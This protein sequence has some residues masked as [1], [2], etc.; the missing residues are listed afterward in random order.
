MKNINLSP[1]D[2]YKIYKISYSVAESRGKKKQNIINEVVIDSLKKLDSYKDCVFKEEVRMNPLWGKYFPVDIAIYRNDVLIEIVLNKAPASNAKQNKV[3]TMNSINSDIDRL[4]NYKNIKITLV[5]F[6]PNITPF[7]TRK[8][9]I[10][11]FENN[12]LDFLMNKGVTKKVDIDEIFITF[13]IS[14]IT[15]CLN[16][17]DIKNLF[18]NNPISNIK[19]EELNYKPL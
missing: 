9:S 2:I 13:D 4:S 18:N 16:K 1:D 17:S 3:N 15:K 19:I 10:K 7:F 14:N 11:N 5:N 12:K 6:L 8:E